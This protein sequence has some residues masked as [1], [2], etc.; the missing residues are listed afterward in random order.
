[1]PAGGYEFD[2]ATT[3]TRIAGTTDEIRFRGEIHDGWDIMGNANGGY[4]MALA[5][6]GLREIADRP[7]PVTVT[8]H[9]L[10]P[11]PAGPIEVRGSLV[12][13]G[14]RFATVAGSLVSAPGPDGEPGR[15]LIRVMAAFGDLAAT[16][17]GYTR[18]DGMAPDLPPF[19]QSPSRRGAPTGPGASPGLSPGVSPAA[20]S[21]A[22]MDRLDVRLR[23]GDL[24]FAHGV[25]TGSPSIAGWF[26]FADG[27]PVD[28]LAL[29]LV[30]DAFPPPVFNIEMPPGWVPTVELTVH[31]RGVPAPGPLRC[32][33]ATRFIQGGYLEEDGE[34]WDSAGRLVAMSRQLALVPRP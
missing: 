22:L 21:P 16:A 31:V 2:I 10:A 9:Y 23:P 30:A 33:F 29:L 24:G 8:A 11:A 5:A 15:E 1:V 19:A 27:R 6:S 34:V 14:K 25:K 12:K 13:T 18:M 32:R 3:L 20:S 17:D 26:G 28:T 7:D 4:L